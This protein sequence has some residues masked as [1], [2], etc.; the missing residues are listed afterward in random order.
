MD[1]K[2]LYVVYEAWIF[3]R[4]GYKPH[5]EYKSQRYSLYLNA[6]NKNQSMQVLLLLVSF[7]TFLVQS[8][9]TEGSGSSISKKNHMNG[10]AP[11]VLHRRRVK[12]VP[13]GGLS[14][15]G[16]LLNSNGASQPKA[17]KG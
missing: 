8:A 15:V 16:A 5:Q 9:P 2:Y 4:R 12:A 7:M 14:N 13:K 17:K 11:H 10:K 1:R 6:K 3:K